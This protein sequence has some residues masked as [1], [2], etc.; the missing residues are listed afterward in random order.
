MGSHRLCGGRALAL[1]PP[2]P[3][4]KGDNDTFEDFTLVIMWRIDL[5][6]QEPRCEAGGQ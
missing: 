2:G 4:D 3:L 1:G 5:G 6:K